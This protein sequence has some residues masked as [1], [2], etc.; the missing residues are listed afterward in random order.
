M[1]SCSLLRFSRVASFDLQH[2]DLGVDRKMEDGIW[3]VRQ[4]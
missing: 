2:F 3:K 1:V 4:W